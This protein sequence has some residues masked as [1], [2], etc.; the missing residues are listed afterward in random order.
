MENCFVIYSIQSFPEKLLEHE[1]I[2]IRYDEINHLINPNLKSL[3]HKMVILHPVTFK[4]DEEYNL[5]KVL[6]A[7]DLNTLFTKLN[8]NDYCK[9][10]ES[11]TDKKKLLDQYEQY[12][13]IIEN[14]KYIVNECSFDF[15]FRTPKNKKHYTESKEN[16]LKLL[17][18]LAY[19]GLARRYPDH[20]RQAVERVEKELAVIE[21]LNF[22]G[23]FLITWDIIQ[24][25]NSMGFMHVGRGSGA[26]SI[27]AYCLGI[28]DICPLEL[29]LYFE[30]FLNLNRKS[31]PDFDID[32]SWKNRDTI[33]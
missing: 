18:Q 6:R 17:Y 28:S 16:D 29:D 2:G 27:I 10:N 7:I 3:I 30:R 19:E 21:Q 11:F 32:W 9:N 1:F 26:N 15:D 31:P 14:T 33:L 13:E 8:E 24:Y 23:Y 22:C 20:N 12:P 4:N 25:S 5:H